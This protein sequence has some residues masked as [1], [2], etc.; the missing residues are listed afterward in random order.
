MATKGGDD[1]L[2]CSPDPC[3]CNKR[4]ARKSTGAPAKPKA[5]ALP[6]RK[7]VGAP[8]TS[9]VPVVEP[10]PQPRARF[11]PSS[12][13][14]IR[15]EEDLMHRRAITVLV[16]AGLIDVDYLDAHRREIDLPD[17]QID[18]LIWKHQNGRERT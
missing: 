4:S 2:L 14:N 15:S 12:V 13:R 8:V 17:W 7:P 5:V 11:N 1:C 10:E 16:N 6:P 3:E 9:T 18:A